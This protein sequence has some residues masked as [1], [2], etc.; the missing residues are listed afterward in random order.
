[1]TAT[2]RRSRGG[3]SGCVALLFFSFGAELLLEFAAARSPF[4]ALP[5]GIAVPAT[6][7]MNMGAFATARRRRKARCCPGT[8]LG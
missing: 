4:L 3:C 1:M 6:C 2:S 7:V 8:A 5:R